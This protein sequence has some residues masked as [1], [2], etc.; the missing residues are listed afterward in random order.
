[1]KQILLICT[2]S[3]L[4]ATGWS[5]DQMAIRLNEKGILKVL[6]AGLKYNASGNK[7]TFKVPA[8][9]YKFTLKKSQILKNPIIPII[10]E[11]SDLNLNRDLD[12]FLHTSDVMIT[13]AVSPQTLKATIIKSYPNGFDFKL[14]LSFPQVVVVAKEM[15]LCENKARNAKKCGTGLK[16]TVQNLKITSKGR[17][18]SLSATFRLLSQN[19]EA[20]VKVLSVSSNLETRQG[21]ALEISTGAVT[22]PP[23]SL[24][25]ND[26]ETRLDTS[27]LRAEIMKRKQFLASKLMTF[28]ADFITGD[29]AE[30]MNVYL[31]RKRVATSWETELYKTFD[32]LGEEIVAVD[33]LED[34]DFLKDL[35]IDDADPMKTLMD[36][37]AAII[38]KSKVKVKLKKISTPMNK[39]IELYGELG[40]SLNGRA[41]TVKN[42]LGNSNRTLP[43]L[44]LANHRTEDINL[45]IS[46]PLINGVLDLASSTGVFQKLFDQMAGVKGFSISNVK[47][48]FTERN[49][50][51]A[52]VNAQIDL[53]SVNSDGLGDWFKNTIAAILERNNNNAVIYFPLDMEILPVVTKLPSGEVKLQLK[54]LSPFEKEGLTNKFKYPTNVNRMYESVRRGVMKK[55]NKSLLTYVDRSYEVD[56]SKFLNQS[57]VTFLPTKISVEQSAYLMMNL[58]IVDIKFNSQN[59]LAR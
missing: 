42:T 22:I 17:P 54:V 28:A 23:I 15:S 6:Q 3:L 32:E 30:M 49:T 31:S 47:A 41:M 25:V 58:S 36:K 29:L 33:T 16:A 52:V 13:G 53:K 37:L 14:S 19:G 39:D 40:L 9:L 7:K 21:P 1:M 59:P 12:Y 4:S 20:L 34:E 26:L 50:I 27:E 10:N 46:E 55:L 18:A 11:V 38:H 43:A 8:N 45:A 57:G 35:D 5:Q 51:M 56:V 2:L 44:S 48:H 24:I